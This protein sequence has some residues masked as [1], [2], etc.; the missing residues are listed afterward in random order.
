MTLSLP[1]KGTAKECRLKKN[2]K[3]AEVEGGKETLVGKTKAL[4]GS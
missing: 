2:N 1:Y 3:S 4:Y